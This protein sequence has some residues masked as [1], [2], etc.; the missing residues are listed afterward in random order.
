MIRSVFRLTTLAA[1]SLCGAVAFP[2]QTN[3]ATA[4]PQIAAAENTPLLR[5]VPDEILLA[6]AV[7]PQ[8]LLTDPGLQEILQAAAAADLPQL[9]SQYTAKTV[10]LEPLQIAELI[11]V[12]DQ[13]TARL[14][15]PQQGS[16]E[17]VQNEFM[18]MQAVASAMT[19]FYDEHGFFPD[20]DGFGKS[21]GRLSWRVHLLPYLEQQDLYSQFRLEEPW[22]SEHNKTLIEKMPEVFK[23]PDI[24]AAGKTSIH[25]LLGEG[26]LFS[27]DEP[28][29]LESITDSPDSTILAVLAEPGTA[30]IW[31]RPGGVKTDMRNPVSSF[32]AGLPAVIACMVD[33]N[34]A[35]LNTTATPDHWRWLIRHTDG[36]WHLPLPWQPA[37]APVPPA[38]LVRFTAAID[39]PKLLTGILGDLPA[40]EQQVA[41]QRGY[42]I[43]SQSTAV[44]PDDR[45]ML[46]SGT[47]SLKLMLAPRAAV[48]PLRQLLETQLA[49]ADVAAVGDLTGLKTALSEPAAENQP[50]AE[51]A[52]PREQFTLRVNATGT[53]KNIV[54]LNVTFSDTDKARQFLNFTTIM[55]QMNAEFVAPEMPERS[56]STEL[57]QYL[58]S[59]PFSQQENEVSL[60]IA[61]PDSLQ[62]VSAALQMTLKAMASECRGPEQPS[63]A[64]DQALALADVAQALGT[65]HDVND[66]FPNWKKF[67]KSTAGLS[68]R[69]HLLQVLDPDLYIRFH[70]DEPWDSPH[71]KTLIAEMPGAF[72]TPGVNEPGQTSLHVFLGPDTICG[73]DDTYSLDDLSAP[74]QNLL[75]FVAGPDTAEIWTKPT[76]LQYDAAD[77]V[78]SLG[79]IGETFWAV[80]TA[81]GQVVE[82]ERKMAPAELR[83]AIERRE[84]N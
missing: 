81:E 10:G 76:G 60:Q 73:A 61:R 39:Q 69:V 2:Q 22:D 27:G 65:F 8:R 13:H 74:A 54:E 4:T 9:L 64:P 80:G 48:A 71:N 68:W 30:E 35:S 21:K 5:Y 41:G 56:W 31:T 18:Q 29:T 28:P 1:A 51:K 43:N 46:I 79:R 38:L 84:A 17:R 47:D 82:L 44:F 53:A 40:T 57:M 49:T 26:S 19:Q 77:P 42:R 72:R 34:T 24:V 67:R 62:P 16:A 37:Q 3:P 45:T 66:C 20:D 23:V 32:A 11:L 6:A 83:K 52:T 25:V 75:A 55:D 78:K 15:Q 50:A 58:Y 63:G 36:H 12:L 14:R 33:G 59:Q 7:R 70:M